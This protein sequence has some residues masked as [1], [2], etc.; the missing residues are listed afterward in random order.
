MLRLLNK[1]GIPNLVSFTLSSSNATL[2]SKLY[3]SASNC[4]TM[5]NITK[6]WR[7]EKSNRYLSKQ[8]KRLLKY[9]A[10][11]QLEKFNWLSI[12]ILNSYSFQV[13]AYNSVANKWYTLKIS[14]VKSHL[15][16]IRYLCFTQSNKIDMTREWISKQTSKRGPD[17]AR[18]LGVPKI[19]WRVYLRMVTNIGEI[20]ASGRKLYADHQ[21]GGRPGR[22]VLSCLTKLVKILPKYRYAWEYDLKGFFDHISHESMRK[23]FEGTWLERLY[24]RMLTSKPTKYIL[25]PST[26]Q[27]K[28][29]DA[30]RKK[31]VESKK[32]QPLW[33]TAMEKRRKLLEKYPSPWTEHINKYAKIMMGN[34]TDKEREIF[35]NLMIA[36]K[37]HLIK[38]GAETLP[39]LQPEVKEMG[40][41]RD[42]WKDLHL[43][44]F[45]IPQGTSF[46]PFIASLLSG[47]V[48]KGL[49]MKQ[50]LYIDDGI[51]FFNDLADHPRER[52]IN[53]FKAIGVEIQESK[54]KTHNLWE[55][56]EG[57]RFLGTRSFSTKNV[58]RMISETR[59]GVSKEVVT[60]TM[61]KEFLMNMK[62]MGRITVSKFKIM[63][64]FI[65]K[66]PT[67]AIG[68]ADTLRTAIK[69]GF[70]GKLLASA[71]DPNK[72]P[73][74]MI[75]QIQEGISK[76][77]EKVKRSSN[78]VGKE[79]LENR[80]YEFTDING[81]TQVGF[82]S[83]NN[84]STF[85]TLRLL[86]VGKDGLRK[87]HVRK[88]LA[89]SKKVEVVHGRR[90]VIILQN[91][92]PLY[93]LYPTRW[94][95][96]NPYN[97]SLYWDYGESYQNMARL[98]F[99][100]G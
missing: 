78:S 94:Y 82:V 66:F 43:E 17:Y 51:I 33:D 80:H 53:A 40:P 88:I 70:F 77:V 3:G 75:R 67:Q 89:G 50:L 49:R 97:N 65:D 36:Q 24:G 73:D 61:L 25:P 62:D 16:T 71:Y 8:F 34:P 30:M 58:L 7:I 46:G 52:L 60:T 84:L 5:E 44:N 22:G 56:T 45:G 41:G 69:F 39:T 91:K 27:M 28:M 20:Y 38:I 92:V 96:Y 98:Y 32:L 79:L 87:V 4:R 85:A 63:T 42:A 37:Q 57:I 21:H 100:E 68:N 6:V 72:D 59:K 48:T 55:N 95:G 76:A 83:L 11:G 35:Q 26:M 74:D 86:E 29:R 23:L 14:T 2:A 93:L 1:Y 9:S 64:W 47:L 54:C 19:T 10:E 31:L 99:E 90:H 12:K 13:Q 81:D 18:P 15:R